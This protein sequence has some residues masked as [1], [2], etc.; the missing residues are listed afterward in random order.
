[1]RNLSTRQYLDFVVQIQQLSLQL[2]KDSCWVKQHVVER[3]EYRLLM[4][5][6]VYRSAFPNQAIY[7]S[8]TGAGCSG[9][10]LTQLI[11]D[12]SGTYPIMTKCTPFPF[13]LAIPIY[14][15]IA[16]HFILRR[17]GNSYSR[18]QRPSTSIQ[19]V[20]TFRDRSRTGLKTPRCRAL[21]RQN[22]GHLT[23]LGGSVLG[24][25]SGESAELVSFEG[26]IG[27]GGSCS[28]SIILTHSAHTSIR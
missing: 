11:G 14:I 22:L 10:F 7:F 16:T 21:A 15:Q 19:R 2:G 26:A 1:M 18:R 12:L 5:V 8:C 6:Q 28:S 9:L 3:P 25:C 23:D 27:F 24:H 17:L 4:T 20:R 13:I